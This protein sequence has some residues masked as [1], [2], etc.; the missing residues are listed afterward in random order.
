MEGQISFR[1]SLQ[2]RLQLFTST[3]S[4]IFQLISILQNSISASILPYH[5]WFQAHSSQ[6]YIISGGFQDYILPVVQEFHIL[7]SHVLANK[8]VFDSHNQ[9]IGFELENPLSQPGGKALAVQKL[10][11]ANPVYIVGDGYTDYQIKE[12]QP[13]FK[14][15]VFTEN[16]SRDTVIAKADFQAHNWSEVLNYLHKSI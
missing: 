3:R 15:I 7:P 4:A 5:S 8:F 13:Q 11:L 16:I 10:Q 14:F 1:Q 9:I 12:S 2:Q 6:I